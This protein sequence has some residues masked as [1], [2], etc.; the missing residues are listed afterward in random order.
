MIKG[1][2]NPVTA[3]LSLAISAGVNCILNPIF[4]FGLKLGIVGSALATDLAQAVVVVWLLAV[5][6][7]TKT[8]LRLRARSLAIRP[9]IL[10]EILSVGLA[11]SFMQ[12]ANAATLILVNNMIGGYAGHTGIAVVG[13]ASSI[14][15]LMLM[16]MFG[17]RSGV[18]PIIGYNY[19]AGANGR[20]RSALYIALVATVAACTAAYGLFFLFSREVLSLFVKNAPEVVILGIPSLRIFLASIPIVGITIVGSAYFQAI[21][22][23][24]LSLLINVV[25]QLILLVPLLL[26]LPRYLGIQ[27]VWL[28]GPLSDA[29]SVVLTVTLL[30]PEMRRLARRSIE[31]PPEKDAPPMMSVPLDT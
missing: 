4:I 22:K 20:V 19:G 7:R 11:P 18:Q 25:R 9:R 30:V 27:G 15:N 10:T 6:L 13:I 29:L 21:K 2:G 24:M 12:I 28:A 3:L 26:L 8:G 23:S 1:Q 14:M 16:P 5:Y 17:I 31:T